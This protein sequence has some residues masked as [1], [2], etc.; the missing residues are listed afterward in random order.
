MLKITVERDTQDSTF[1]VGDLVTLKLSRTGDDC[2]CIVLVT[3]GRSLEPDLF[4]GVVLFD[5]EG[6]DNFRVGT[7][8]TDFVKSYFKKFIGKISLESK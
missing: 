8:H 7:H 3:G 6:D 2:E 5:Q 1:D 4:H